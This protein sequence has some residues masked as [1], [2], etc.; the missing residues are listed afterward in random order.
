[1]SGKFEIQRTVVIVI[2][3]MRVRVE[4]SKMQNW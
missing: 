4:V 3:L 1:M 2:P